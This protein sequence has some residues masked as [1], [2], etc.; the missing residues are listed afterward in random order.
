[1]P[2]VRRIDQP[3]EPPDRESGGHKGTF[4]RVVVVAGSRGMSGAAALC[5]LG[6][7]RGGAGLVFV[8]IPDRIVET[9]ASVEPALL[10]VPIPDDATGRFTASSLR[11]ALDAISKADAVVLG[12]GIGQIDESRQFVRS[13]LDA[14]E[15]PLVLDADGL[16]AVASSGPPFDFGPGPRIL[17]PH[18]G[19]FSRLT[20]RSI[21][22]VQASRETSAIE[23]AKQTGAV[24]VLKGAG[25]VVTDGEQL[26]VN[27]TGNSGM[28]TGGTGDVLAGLLA[29][30][31]GQGMSHFDAAC[32]GAHLHGL[33]GDLSAAELTE[34]GMIAT[35]LAWFLTRAWEVVLGEEG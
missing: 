26:F 3:P 35:D 32:F 8:A 1:M 25:T 34:P 9:V 15:G 23:F 31:L 11:P 6:A 4:G 22:D 21:H 30:L 16:N 24:V 29:A 33:A 10:T 12:P 19:E 7:L 20:G 28:G 5:G 18:P 2:D 14:F 17:T 27:S 13:V